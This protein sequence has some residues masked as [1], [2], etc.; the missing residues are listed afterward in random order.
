M[1]PVAVIAPDAAMLLVFV[2]VA[3]RFITPFVDEI[4]D[5]W[6]FTALFVN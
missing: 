5:H 3:L 4:D 2:V 6:A 1:F